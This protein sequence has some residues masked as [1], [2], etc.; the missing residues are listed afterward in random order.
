[1]DFSE[2]LRFIRTQ[3]GLSQ[4]QLATSVGVSV[5]T[6]GCWEKGIKNP[7]LNYII[8]LTKTLGISADDLLDLSSPSGF[9]SGLLSESEF[10]L[11]TDYRELDVYG[12]KAVETLCSLEKS[13]IVCENRMRCKQL[14]TT[15][16]SRGFI[17]K[18]TSPAAA[19]YAAPI[20]GDDYEMIQVDDNVPYNADYAVE[21]HG[22]S[23]IPYIQ[24]GETVYVSRD[25][26]VS[27][28]DV[29][30]FNVNGETYCKQYYADDFG[31]LTLI[32]SNPA[33]K[34]SNVQIKTD[35]G[36]SVR[37]YGRVLLGRKVP[38][39]TYFMQ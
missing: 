22:T 16:T 3:R 27:I 21:I 18:Y 20:E 11:I 6:I 23:M 26:D 35:S 8:E 14:K 31:N 13:R 1:M 19:G 38:I 33:L 28:G 36:F 15:D 25:S 39:P 10:K 17:P 32:S 4:S 5:R 29:G 7:T 37:C 12:K 34:S 30:I 2:R 24:D 9:V